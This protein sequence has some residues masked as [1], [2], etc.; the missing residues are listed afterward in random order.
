MF[1]VASMEA[2]AAVPYWRFISVDGGIG[3]G[4]VWSNTK[5]VPLNKVLIPRLKLQGVVLG[6][7]LKQNLLNERK[8]YQA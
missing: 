2:F 7:R 6:I 8:Q 5:C 4:F 1:L 3:G